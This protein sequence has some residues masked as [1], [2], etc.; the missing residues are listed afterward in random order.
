MKKGQMNGFTLLIT[1]LVASFIF[2]GLL[3]WHQGIADLH[4]AEIDPQYLDTYGRINDT[5][6]ETQTLTGNLEEKAQ[7]GGD[8][9]TETIEIAA[10]KAAFEAAVIFL[11]APRLAIGIIMDVLG[12]LGFAYWVLIGITTILII[13]AIFATLAYLRGRNL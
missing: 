11:K 5:L 2:I 8:V 6:Q 9:G 7:S 3:S 1:I 13:T 10:P 12:N 4:N